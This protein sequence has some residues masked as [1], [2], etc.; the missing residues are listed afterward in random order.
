LNRDRDSVLGVLEEV[1]MR[2]AKLI[3]L[4]LGVA[5]GIGQAALA[6]AATPQIPSAG[7]AE[8]SVP[9]SPIGPPASSRH[10]HHSTAARHARAVTHKKHGKRTKHLAKRHHTSHKIG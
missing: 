2:N 10:T 4:A 5:I 1:G 9:P 6:G 3:A 7:S 8:V